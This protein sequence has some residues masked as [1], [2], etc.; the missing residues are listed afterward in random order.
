MLDF[1][2]ALFSV[3]VQNRLRD[4]ISASTSRRSNQSPISTYI[5]AQT[6]LL[7][8]TG[9]SPRPAF[10]AL[11]TRLVARLNEG[12][13]GALDVEGLIDVLTMKMNEAEGEREDAAVALDVLSR[14]TVSP[15]GMWSRRV[16]EREG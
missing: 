11:F 3:Q 15:L 9:L 4:A 8:A 13:G 16:C 2:N 6:K 14:T 12:G 10:K 7:D 5:A 1:D